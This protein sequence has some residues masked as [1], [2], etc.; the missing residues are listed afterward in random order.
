MKKEK[1]KINDLL[2]SATSTTDAINIAYSRIKSLSEL[3]EQFMILKF[4]NYDSNQTVFKVSTYD[5]IGWLFIKVNKNV[6]SKEQYEIIEEYVNT[7][8]YHRVVKKAKI[9]ISTM[10]CY[11]D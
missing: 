6:V 8:L 4:G 10:Y 3:L 7:T 11:I 9:M 2:I 1:I 5:D